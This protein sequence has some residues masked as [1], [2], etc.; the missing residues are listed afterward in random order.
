MENKNL[1]TQYL[2]ALAQNIGKVSN[3]SLAWDLTNEVIMAVKKKYDFLNNVKIDQ[4]LDV[5]PD[6]NKVEKEKIHEFFNSFSLDFKKNFNSDDI[7]PDKIKDLKDMLS[8]EY[9]SIEEVELEIDYMKS[10]L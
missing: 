9:G 3:M 4:K 1:L 2:T 8:D 7:H 10:L 6:I 5:A